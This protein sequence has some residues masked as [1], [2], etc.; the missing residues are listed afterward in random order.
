MNMKAC[1]G[2][3]RLL[4]SHLFTFGNFFVTCTRV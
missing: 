3:K 4:G 2:T 1:H